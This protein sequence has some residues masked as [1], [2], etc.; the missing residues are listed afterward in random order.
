VENL[1]RRATRRRDF[2]VQ[3]LRRFDLRGLR[4]VFARA[5]RRPEKK[6]AALKLCK[7]EQAVEESAVSGECDPIFHTLINTCVENLIWQKYFSL[8]SARRV[9]LRRKFLTAP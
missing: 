2:L 7:Q 4:F 5:N 1:N 9:P 6:I 8:T 3:V